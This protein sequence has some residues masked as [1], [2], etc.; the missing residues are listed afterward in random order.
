M[1]GAGA[2]GFCILYLSRIQLEEYL[3]EL[4]LEMGTFYRR[5]S[6]FIIHNTFV[7]VFQEIVG[8]S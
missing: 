4:I 1:P 2:P 8:T 6:V 3:L 7:P 5:F